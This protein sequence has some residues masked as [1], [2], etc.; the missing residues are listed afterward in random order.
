VGDASQGWHIF[1]TR[2]KPCVV[3]VWWCYFLQVWLYSLRV[4]YKPFTTV[5]ASGVK[6]DS[7][8]WNCK[9]QCFFNMLT[10]F[11]LTT[12]IITFTRNLFHDSR[13][14][15]ALRFSI[16]TR[17]VQF[18]FMYRNIILSDNS[19]HY[20]YSYCLLW[21]QAVQHSP[22]SHFPRVL[23]N[24]LQLLIKCLLTAFEEDA[25]SAR[26]R[27]A[28]TRH[29]WCVVDCTLKFYNWSEPMRS[30]WEQLTD[31]IMSLH[32]VTYCVKCSCIFASNDVNLKRKCR[33]WIS[34]GL[35]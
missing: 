2:Y 34:Y 20:F 10:L 7:Q 15:S 29:I 18:F 19:R 22:L 28:D 27:L 9:L 25:G 16:S 17:F 5:G 24:V 3:T 8:Y 33:R 26:V 12:P 23:F 13:Q 11:Y 35:C 30:N 4:F 1:A 32:N 14:R 21:H 6:N 31:K